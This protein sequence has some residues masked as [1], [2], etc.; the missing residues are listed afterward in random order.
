LALGG[1]R[2]TP[3]GKKLSNNFFLIN[4]LSYFIIF[5]FFFI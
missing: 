4:F 5:N 3:N 1:G 2:T